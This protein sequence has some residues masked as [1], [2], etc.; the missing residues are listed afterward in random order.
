LPHGRYKPE[1]DFAIDLPSSDLRRKGATM[2]VEVAER[3]RHMKSASS[4]G[5]ARATWL[6]F[7]AVT[8]ALLGAAGV[9]VVARRRRRDGRS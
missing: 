8:A 1:D 6:P 5:K 7:V 3:R 9:A 4:A 2:I